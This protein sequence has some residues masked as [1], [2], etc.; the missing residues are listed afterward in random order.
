MRNIHAS[1]STLADR[2]IVTAL[3]FGVFIW[4]SLHTA[5]AGFPAATATDHGLASLIA[6]ELGLALLA[7]VYLHMRGHDLRLLLPVPS[8]HGMLAGIALFAACLAASRLME[9]AFAGA[10]AHAMHDLLAD[11]R[12]SFLPLA[13]TALINGVYEETFLLGFLQRTLHAAG[14]QLAIAAALLV[15]V[16]CHLYQGPQGALSVFGAGL[17][18]G[19]YFAKTGN[20][21]AAVLAHVALDSAEFAM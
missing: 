7:L 8:A 4:S 14:P 1:A 20:L 6:I 19:F 17:V 9:F 16:L 12:V 10:P 15:R 5:A 21:W 13:A 3:C 2:V 11:G 18:L